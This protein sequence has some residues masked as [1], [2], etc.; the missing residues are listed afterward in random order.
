ME[1]ITNADYTHSIMV[2]TMICIFKVIHC[3]FKETDVFEGFRNMFLQIYELDPARF[4]TATGLARQ[5]ALKMN[6]AKLDFF[7]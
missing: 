5:I 3:M 1:D 7:N 6:K 4:L 2:N